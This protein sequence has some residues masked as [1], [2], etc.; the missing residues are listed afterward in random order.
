MLFVFITQVLV[1]AIVVGY[2]AQHTYYKVERLRLTRKLLVKVNKVDAQC[3]WYR[4]SI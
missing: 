4:M 3:C 2:K 1:W